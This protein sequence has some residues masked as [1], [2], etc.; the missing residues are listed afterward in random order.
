[1]ISF[2]LKN[3]SDIWAKLDRNGRL[4]TESCS[5]VISKGEVGIAVNSAGLV[6]SN[7]TLEMV[8]ALTWDQPQV[9]FKEHEQVFTRYAFH[10]YLLPFQFCYDFV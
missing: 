8:F 6:R 2:D 4:D 7:S 1:M 5:Y 3:G 10:P 9:T